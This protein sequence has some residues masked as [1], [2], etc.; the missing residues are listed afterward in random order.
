MGLDLGCRFQLKLGLGSKNVECLTSLAMYD[1]QIFHEKSV[2]FLINLSMDNYIIFFIIYLNTGLNILS[3][4]QRILYDIDLFALENHINQVKNKEVFCYFYKNVNII[5]IST[6]NYLSFLIKFSHISI[7]VFISN[8]Y[9][10]LDP[11]LE[12]TSLVSLAS[13]SSAPAV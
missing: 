8:A 10:T 4:A 6:N 7:S 9:S 12:K 2:I 1:I 3:V 5:T 13:F 11:I